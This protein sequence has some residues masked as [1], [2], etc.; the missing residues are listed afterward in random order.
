MNNLEGFL[1]VLFFWFVGMR[2]IGEIGLEINNPKGNKKGY[3]K[4]AKEMINKAEVPKIN[5]DKPYLII[6]NQ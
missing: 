3:T 4:E 5:I 6:N 2:V 1:P